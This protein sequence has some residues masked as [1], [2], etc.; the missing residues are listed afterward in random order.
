MTDKTALFFTKDEIL[1][2]LDILEDARFRVVVAR[3]LNEGA[4]TENRCERTIVGLDDLR[5]RFNL[6]TCGVR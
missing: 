6:A 4:N 5:Y 2:V 1:D 3:S